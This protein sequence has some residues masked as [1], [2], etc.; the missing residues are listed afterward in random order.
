MINLTIYNFI[1]YVG[2]AWG[3]NILFN[4]LYVLKRYRP[5]YVSMD[6]PIDA[7]I[8]LSGNRLIGESTT[9]FGLLIAIIAS[10][11]VYIIF[12]DFYLAII[13]LLVY[14]GHTIGSFIKRRFGIEDGKFMPIVDHGDYMITTGLVLLCFGYIS[15][16]LALAGLV[17]TY[18]FHP[19]ACFVAY[20]LK[21]RQYPY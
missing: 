6:R 4:L 11:T 19:L 21:L 14:L 1:L 18:I 16:A 5:T 3:T 12:N 13:P 7:N 17:F 9:V 10:I 15:W 20:K 8:I 2:I